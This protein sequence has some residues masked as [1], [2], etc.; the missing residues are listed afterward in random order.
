MKTSNFITTTALSLVIFMSVSSI[1]NPAMNP[2]GEETKTGIKNQISISETTI[3][4]IASTT[5]NNFSY[6][7]FEVDKFVNESEVAELPATSTDYL[8]FDVNN[9]SADENEISE[10]PVSEAFSYLRFD[11]NKYSVE[12]TPVID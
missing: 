3:S 6:L 5:E 12:N 1:A 11:V 7:R 2:S 4:R 10:L 8:R 9:F